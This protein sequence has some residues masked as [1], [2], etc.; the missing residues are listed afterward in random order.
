MNLREL[1]GVLTIFKNIKLLKNYA[2]YVEKELTENEI[3]AL[4]YI[5]GGQMMLQHL[6]TLNRYI[7][8]PRWLHFSSTA[9][10]LRESQ[11][12]IHLIRVVVEILII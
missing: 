1:K 9:N 5:I 7:F 4:H 2:V 10:L 3:C 8:V 12:N 11:S 6:S